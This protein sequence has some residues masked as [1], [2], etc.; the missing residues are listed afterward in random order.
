MLNVLTDSKPSRRAHGRGLA[1]PLAL[2]LLVF[3]VLLAVPASS[4]AAPPLG[5]LT[6]L[7]SP[8]NCV[9]EAGYHE[10][11]IGCG[12]LLP[13]EALN[14]TYEAQVSPDG[15]NVYSVAV[16]GALV[17]YSRDATTGALTP[18]G[19]VTSASEPCAS[20]NVTLNAPGMANPAAIALS[21][22]GK[23]A[24]VVTKGGNAIVELSRNAETGLLTEIGCIDEAS[25]ACGSHEARGIANP[26][27]VTVSPDGENVYV[28]SFEKEA[29]AELSRDPATGLLTQLA[30]PNNCISSLTIETTGCG[31]GNAPGLEHVIGL[32][33]TPNGKDLYTAAGGTEGKGAIAAFERKPGGALE[34]LGGGQG[35]IS[36][37]NRECAAAAAIDGPE[38]LI[39]SPDGRNV[40]VSS[41]QNNAVL[42]LQ[43]EPSGALAELPPPNRCIMTP[44]EKVPAEAGCSETKGL[45]EPLGVAISPGG[46]SVYA[47]SSLEDDEA[48]FTRN[49]DTGALTSLPAPY[50]CAGKVERSTCGLTDIEGIAEAR[51]TTV[52]PDG[53]NL[54]VAGQNDHAI[55]ELARAVPE[56]EPAPKSEEAPKTPLTATVQPVAM[57]LAVPPPVLG[58]TGNVAPVSGGVSLR[59]PGASKFAPLS[60]L[61][62]IPFGTVIDATRGRVSVTVTLPNGKTQT[63]EF[64]SGEFVLRQGANGLVIAE[65]TGGN[66]SVCPTKRE[67]AHI[68]GSV[69]SSLRFVGAG[70]PGFMSAGLPG[71]VS[72][73]SPS[74]SA[75]AA[76]GSHVVRKLW[77]NAHGKFSTKGNYAAGAVQGTEWLTEDRCDGTYIKVTRDRVAVTNLVNHRHVEVASGRHYLAKAPRG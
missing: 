72:A 45:A 63:G 64:F 67:R 29:V 43:H 42:E 9:G 27:D 58:K 12:T 3:A 28:T 14:R 34:Q 8:F 31:V 75:A 77:A 40:Y 71:S 68:A 46:E 17:E 52:S 47:S 18:I 22:D 60:T 59:A 30:L 21:P 13:A 26:Y 51:R 25:T 66:F 70:L 33:V 4:G 16:L 23:N 37:S 19:C 24:Y 44:T 76:S 49:A 41:N 11:V 55:V 7:A 15:K 35:C 61:V 48:V 20:S 1:L 53:R 74:A 50:E 73:G 39:V 57:P 36:T 5:S 38:D 69:A 10:E 6:Q 2:A 65:L 32:V 54:Y 56:P 62:Q